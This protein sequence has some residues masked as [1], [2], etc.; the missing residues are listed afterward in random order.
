MIVCKKKCLFFFTV[1]PSVVASNLGL[2]Q[3]VQQAAGGAGGNYKI[4]YVQTYEV[5]SSEIVMAEKTCQVRELSERE[6]MP[7]CLRTVCSV[8]FALG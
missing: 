4:Q 8:N 3:W 2:D 5:I 7:S 1:S 6:G